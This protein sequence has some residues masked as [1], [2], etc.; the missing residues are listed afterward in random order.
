MAVHRDCFTFEPGV[1]HGLRC[2]NA[3]QQYVALGVN[4]AF[5]GETHKEG[6]IDPSSVLP[7]GAPAFGGYIL[8][9]LT[10]SSEEDRRNDDDDDERDWI[11]STTVMS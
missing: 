5:H 4:C 9:T 2:H 1:R 7:L 11:E 10:I 3:S 8:A 6:C